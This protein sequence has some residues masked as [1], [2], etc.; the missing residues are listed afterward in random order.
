MKKVI[1]LCSLMS[2][3]SIVSAQTTRYDVN[4]YTNPLPTVEYT[5][6]MGDA[7]QKMMQLYQ[8]TSRNNA[9]ERIQLE[10]EQQMR[11]ID[12]MQMAAAEGA[13][14]VSEEVHTFSGVNLA[15]KGVA[16][17]RARI[18]KKKSGYISISCLG[19]KI[20]GNSW[21]PCDKSISSL[22]EMYNEAKSESEKRM[23]L[24]LMDLGNYLLDT[25]TEIYILK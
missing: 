6:P 16:S 18:A 25:G 7:Y 21:T 20:G 24:E 12:R 9:L 2:L 1:V 15:T 23:A 19:I 10:Y 11:E 4:V 17:I 22:Q 5:K 14:I 13:K 8:G 3:T